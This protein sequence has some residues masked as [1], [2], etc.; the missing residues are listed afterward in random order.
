VAVRLN[1]DAGPYAPPD[2]SLGRPKECVGLISSFRAGAD[3]G[4]PSRAG[5]ADAI[6]AAG[7]DDHKAVSG[8]CSKRKKGQ[9]AG[10]RSRPVR[11]AIVETQER[12]ARWKSIAAGSLRHIIP[13]LGKKPLRDLTSAD[14]YKSLSSLTEFHDCA[15]TSKPS[16]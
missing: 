14:D 9:H 10:N 11:S 5:D 12:P 13:L 1:M 4:G 2:E 15:R 8:R 3:L 16:K 7:V 6:Q